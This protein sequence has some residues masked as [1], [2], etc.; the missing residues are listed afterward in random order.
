MV[1]ECT[2]EQLHIIEQEDPQILS[3]FKVQKVRQPSRIQIQE[4]LKNFSAHYRP[5]IEIS[6]GAI[7]RVGELHQQF[8]TYSV[9]PGRPLRFLRNLLDDR[10]P[11][12]IPFSCPEGRSSRWLSPGSRI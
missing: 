9:A 11:P 7:E 4:I 6:S 3:V 8:A 1:A 10:T 2:P 5:Q 12:D